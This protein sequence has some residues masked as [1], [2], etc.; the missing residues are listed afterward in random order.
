MRS[1]T[2]P[3]SIR[4]PPAISTSNQALRVRFSQLPLV[5]VRG[6]LFSL[7]RVPPNGTRACL[8]TFVKFSAHLNLFLTHL[9]QLSNRKK[10][11]KLMYACHRAVS[12]WAFNVLPWAAPSP[13]LP[14]ASC[15]PSAQLPACCST[16]PVFS[17]ASWGL[18][19]D[20]GTWGVGRQEEAI[21]FN[22]HLLYSGV[23]P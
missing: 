9:A 1:R 8:F 21:T 5:Q 16:E 20:L 18:R 2:V 23:G 14:W 13:G 6:W 11:N 19:S 17:E 22:D 15:R 7:T 12:L 4:T 3:G 10:Q